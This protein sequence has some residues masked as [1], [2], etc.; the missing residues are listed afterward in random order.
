MKSLD[1]PRLVFSTLAVILV[2]GILVIVFWKAGEE[3]TSTGPVTAAQKRAGAARDRGLQGGGRVVPSGPSAGVL[4]STI[5]AK[6]GA[7]FKDSSLT[8]GRTQ[9][10]AYRVMEYPGGKPFFGGEPA[11]AFVSVPSSGDNV[12]I[13]PNQVGEFPP[14]YADPGETVDVRVVF[15]ET[16]AGTRV[17]VVAE[18]GGTLTGADGLPAT[19]LELDAG[20]SFAVP[21]TLGAV[22][23]SYRLTIAT[24]DGEPKRLHL[25]AGPAMK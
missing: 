24:A 3:D 12:A 23:G 17:R 5:A 10:A 18:D 14:V 11:V 6:V 1:R 16:K 25:H 2:I 21:F 7:G 13:E 15:P 20:S 22:E 8:K 19:L 9:P 4:V